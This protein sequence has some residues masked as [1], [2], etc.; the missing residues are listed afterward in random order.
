MAK[1][2][3]FLNHFI[4]EDIY[5]IDQDTAS[6]VEPSASVGHLIVTPLPLADQ[7][8]EF[9]YKIFMAVDVPPDMLDLGGPETEFK[10]GHSKVFFFG[11]KP[12]TEITDFYKEI[13]LHD[14]TIVIAHSLSEIAK[15]N[16]KKRELWSV[17]KT[18]FPRL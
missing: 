3:T 15:D 18:C 1:D 17:L 4:T 16:A 2:H 5:L 7:D 12:I 14:R 10:D 13:K 8:K 6:H 9:L 11:T